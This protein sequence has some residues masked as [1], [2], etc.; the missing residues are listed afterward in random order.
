[1]AENYGK[2]KQVIGPT[3]DLEFDSDHLPDILNALHITDAD[4]GIDP[5]IASGPMVTTT[6]DVTGILVFMGL[7]SAF[8]QLL[9]RERWRQRCRRTLQHLN[10][11]GSDIDTRGSL[12][13]PPDG[14][15][16][17]SRGH[18]G[19]FLFQVVP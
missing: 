8:V 19:H 4:K 12:E 5:A 6:N 7:S 14:R 3:V 16:S 1:M 2:V 10:P 13:P 15:G 17:R 18:A 11:P 9:G